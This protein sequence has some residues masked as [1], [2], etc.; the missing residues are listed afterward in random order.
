MS[1]EEDDVAS[2]ACD[3]PSLI[4]T[5]AA[6][7]ACLLSKWAF[8]CISTLHYCFPSSKF[9]ID[10]RLQIVDDQISLVRD[11]DIAGPPTQMEKFLQ[12]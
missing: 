4:F 10:Q 6:F 7:D 1:D 3:L 11:E 12:T 2:S 5:Y 8:W 9:R